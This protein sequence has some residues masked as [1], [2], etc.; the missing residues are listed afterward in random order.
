MNLHGAVF[1]FSAEGSHDVG[2]YLASR[3]KFCDFDEEGSAYIEAEVERLSHVMDGNA[4]LQHLAYIFYGY[5][6]GVSDFLYCLSAAQG[7]YVT[8]YKYSSYAR[9][10]LASPTNGFSH[11]I[12][13]LFQAI[14]VL[15]I[16]QQLCQRAGTDY[17]VQLGH[18][19]SL[20]FD[21]SSHHSE[22][23]ESRFAGVHHERIFSQVQAIEK[24]MYIF[25]CGQAYAG[26]ARFLSV[27][28]VDAMKSRSVETDIIHGRTAINFMFQELIIFLWKCF[29]TGLCNAPWFFLVSIDPLAAHEIAHARII[30]SRKDRILCVRTCAQCINRAECD[31]FVGL[32]IHDFFKRL[33]LQE[34]VA[35]IHPFF[36]PWL[37][38]FIKRYLW[39]IG[40]ALRL[41]QNR[42][43]FFIGKLSFLSFPGCFFGYF[44][45][46][47]YPPLIIL[48]NSTKTEI[49]PPSG[50]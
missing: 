47:I 37:F 19:F 7:E 28:H 14:L 15:A 36:I 1:F 21:S 4:S 30:I 12:V 25:Q 20:S 49:S 24:G 23:S 39:E 33:A 42:F 27:S 3:T 32:G 10:V 16:D 13:A 5:A 48:D 9:S 26:F 29:I 34:C 40:F 22:R 35:G 44:I 8:L 6:E 41:F 50:S 17:T 46:E 45:H 38:K 11:F 31:T 43:Q 2:P 18:I